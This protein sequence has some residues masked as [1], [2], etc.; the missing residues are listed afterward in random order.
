MQCSYCIHAQAEA[1]GQIS[2][3]Y[4]ELCACAEGE[5]VAPTGLALGAV[6]QSESSGSSRHSHAQIVEMLP[7]VSTTAISSADA[8]RLERAAQL[9]QLVHGR[10]KELASSPA[11][12]QQLTHN[13]LQARPR[14]VQCGYTSTWSSWVLRCD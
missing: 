12:Q 11:S 2:V 6:P 8:A 10:A 13:I 1:V 5:A 3:V 4:A 7:A 14:L 9:V